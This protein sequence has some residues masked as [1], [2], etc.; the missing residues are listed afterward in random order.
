MLVRHEQGGDLRRRT[1]IRAS[2]ASAC[3]WPPP[4]GRVEPEFHRH[5]DAMLDSVPMVVLTGQVPTTPDGHRR[6]PTGRVRDDPADGQ[7]RI[8]R[9]RRVDDLPM[10]VAKRFPAGARAA[11]PGA[12]RPA[13]GR[14][15]ADASHLPAY[16]AAGGC[17]GSA[18]G[19]PTNEAL[20]LISQAQRPVVYYGGGIALGD[21][22]GLP[23]PSSMR[24]QIPDRVDPARA[25]QAPPTKHP[26]NLGM[27][28]MHG[29]ARRIP[30]RGV[31][32]ADLS[33]VSAR[34]DDRATGSWPTGTYARVGRAHGPD[35]AEIGML[36]RRRWRARRPAH[37]PWHC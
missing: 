28:G 29:C 34:F 23:A 30:C 15:M 26:M 22:L 37:H 24:R 25:G 9:A 36:C 16:A 6:V 27:L 14:A 7:A 18:E 10:M 1:G 19:C 8:L 33:I 13:E 21:A 12:D 20:A 2:G 35:A 32:E 5:V 3:A 4:A 31:V 17:G 11:L